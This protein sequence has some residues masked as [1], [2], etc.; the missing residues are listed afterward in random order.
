M[1]TATAGLLLAGIVSIAAGI[2]LW[3]DV[4]SAS[5]TLVMF[6]DGCVHP[7]TVLQRALGL[8]ERPWTRPTQVTGGLILLLAGLGMILVHLRRGRP[9]ER[10]KPA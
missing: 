2:G 1:K 10:A 8:P 4:L 9:R 5:T 6:D 3:G 7:P